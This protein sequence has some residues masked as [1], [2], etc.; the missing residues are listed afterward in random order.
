MRVSKIRDGLW[1]WEVPHPD[2]KPEF[3]RPDG[4]G[5]TVA[6]VYA[7]FP[8]A[9]VLIDPLVPPDAAERERFWQALD[10]DVS[11]LA[12]PIW[13]LVG[14]VDHGRSADAVAERY[15]AAGHKLTIVGDAAIRGVVSCTLDATFDEVVLP[16][17]LKI[18]PIPGMSP[19]ETAFLLDP[20]RA[21]VFADAVIGAGDGRLRVAPPSWGIKTPAGR[22]LYDARFR[23]AVH[24]VALARP[25]IVLTSH[26]EAVLTGGAAALEAALA[27][28]AWGA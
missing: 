18:V 27:S 26:G 3:D 24:G 7:E 25:E 20:W 12:R 13:V 10:R 4:W 16:A 5:R 1:R 23:P 21:A 9:V 22:A 14:S 19:G 2:W 28:P 8:E 17:G 11:R 6:A 15:V